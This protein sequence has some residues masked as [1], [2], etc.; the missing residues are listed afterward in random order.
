MTGKKDNPLAG[1][2]EKVVKGEIKTSQYFNEA[3]MI[4]GDSA[5]EEQLGDEYAE[6]FNRLQE[7]APEYER[8]IDHQAPPLNYDMPSPV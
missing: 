1:I 8:E 7:Q 6:M 5:F 2:S 3:R 4:L